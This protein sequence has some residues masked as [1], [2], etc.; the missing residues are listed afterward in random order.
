MTR[1]A[2]SSSHD[3]PSNHLCCFTSFA[4][5]FSMP[6]RLAGLRSSRRLMRSCGGGGCQEGEGSEAIIVW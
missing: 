4:R 6:S 2:S 1:R 3:I 5:P